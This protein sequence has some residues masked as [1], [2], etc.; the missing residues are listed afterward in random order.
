MC[1]NNRINK[2]DR[3]AGVMDNHEEGKLY[4]NH[5][6]RKYLAMQHK[7]V[8]PALNDYF[9]APLPRQDTSPCKY[10]IF[11]R[12][13]YKPGAKGVLAFQAFTAHKMGLT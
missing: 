7:T 3:V 8:M 2:D 13:S 10:C 4:R 5:E 9:S 6:L 1:G 12:S 11:Y